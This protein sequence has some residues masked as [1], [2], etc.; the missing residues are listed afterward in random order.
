M[1]ASYSRELRTVFLAPKAS[2]TEDPDSSTLSHIG[3][4]NCG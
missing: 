4:L 3:V 2:N 1:T